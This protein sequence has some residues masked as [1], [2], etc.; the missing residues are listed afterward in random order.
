MDQVG[1]CV[2]KGA[3][4]CLSLNIVRAYQL[5]RGRKAVTSKQVRS[6]RF[7]EPKSA[8]ELLLIRI[9]AELKG[10]F[11]MYTN[12]RITGSVEMPKGFVQ[13]TQLACFKS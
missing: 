5:R 11:L 13:D 7:N 8:D 10:L 6:R 1:I 2:G 9:N 4:L 3:K 12:S